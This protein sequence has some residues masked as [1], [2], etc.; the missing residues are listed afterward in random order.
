MLLW[1]RIWSLFQNN[2]LYCFKA[3]NGGGWNL[4]MALTL[5]LPNRIWLNV[6][7]LGSFWTFWW[8]NHEN[9]LVFFCMKLDNTCGCITFS[10]IYVNMCSA[11]FRK[12]RFSAGKFTNVENSSVDA[13]EFLRIFF[14]VFVFSSYVWCMP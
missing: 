3:Y 11:N 7:K 5:R 6:Q 12:F 9:F 10:E 13:S 4:W 8:L 1:G 2:K 14:T